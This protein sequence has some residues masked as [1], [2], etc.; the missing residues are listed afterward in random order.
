MG[1][2]RLLVAHKFKGLRPLAALLEGANGRTENDGVHLETALCHVAPDFDGLSP[3]TDRVT[4]ADV[5]IDCDG[6]HL[7]AAL[8]RA[9]E[10][11]ARPES[12]H[13]R[14]HKC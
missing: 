7:D 2:I 3:V 8:H 14:A 4:S 13:R 5:G 1:S 10:Q 9:A 6:V 12:T 11:I